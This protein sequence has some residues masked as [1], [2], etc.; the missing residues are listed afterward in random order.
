LV[1]GTDHRVPPR[2]HPG[3]QRPGPDDSVR[4]AA[5]PILGGAAPARPPT[6]RSADR[7]APAPPVGGPPQTAPTPAHP[8]R[9]S[10]PTAPSPWQSPGLGGD[11]PQ[12][13]ARRRLPA[14]AA[15][16]QATVRAWVERNVTTRL[17]HGLCGPEA[18]RSVTSQVSCIVTPRYKAYL[19]QY[20]EAV[21]GEPARRHAS[22]PHAS[23]SQQRG[24]N[25]SRSVHE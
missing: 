11:S 14:P 8:A 16:A 19:N 7:A 9:P 20:V 4:R 5:S 21:S 25:C 1:E 13:P 6:P 15:G 18:Y 2:G 3:G 23:L 17:G 24:G 22:K 12:S 10:W